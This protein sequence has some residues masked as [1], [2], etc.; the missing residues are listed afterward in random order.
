[1]QSY[2]TFRN[3]NCVIAVHV[4]AS[5]MVEKTVCCVGLLNLEFCSVET[6]RLAWKMLYFEIFSLELTCYLFLQSTYHLCF[7]F[8]PLHMESIYSLCI[9]YHRDCFLLLLLDVSLVALATE[10]FTSYIKLL[11]D[12]CCFVSLEL[13]L[14]S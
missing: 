12:F 4:T 13:S 3:P 8:Q 2:R 7:H 11:A 5:V 9:S 1:M 10:L 14:Q 6:K